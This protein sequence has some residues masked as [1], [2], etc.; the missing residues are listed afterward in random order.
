MTV[1]QVLSPATVA[2]MRSALHAQNVDSDGGGIADGDLFWT[3]EPGADG[4]VI[5]AFTERGGPADELIRGLPEY[6]ERWFVWTTSYMAPGRLPVDQGLQAPGWTTAPGGPL[7]LRRAVNGETEVLDG[8][9]VV[10]TFYLGGSA[11]AFTHYGYL[12][13]ELLIEQIDLPP[14]ES[15]FH[16]LPRRV[17]D[18]RW[19]R[20]NRDAPERIRRWA[21]EQLA[22]EADEERRRR[23][24]EERKR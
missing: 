8:E 4:L 14:D 3:V 22:R 2:W 20:K 19:I 12:P 5:G 17:H 13:V 1:R 21:L 10:A 24:A 16:L 15:V 11:A 6:V 7:T 23:R 9:A 18:R